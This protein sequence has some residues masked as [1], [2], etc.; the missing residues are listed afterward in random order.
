MAG[1]SLVDA[2]RA[3]TLQPASLYRLWDR[4]AV[5]P[6]RRADLL[7]VEDP[8]HPHPRTVLQAGRLVVHEGRR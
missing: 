1:V 8:A 7:L 4:G 6:G 3:A 5:A 2:V